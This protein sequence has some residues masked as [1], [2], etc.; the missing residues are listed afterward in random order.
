M[1][2][3]SQASGEEGEGG[4]QADQP[5]KSIVNYS[6]YYSIIDQNDHKVKL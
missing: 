1:P 6:N 2:I 4:I 3:E 5:L